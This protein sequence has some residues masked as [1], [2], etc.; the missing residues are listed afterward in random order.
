MKD[1]IQ[2]KGGEDL[3]ES[4]IDQSNTEGS[5]KADINI[6]AK[7]ISEGVVHGKDEPL[8]WINF[9]MKYRP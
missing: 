4:G 6:S 2:K 1:D 7:Q 5:A 9:C 3:E 8:Q